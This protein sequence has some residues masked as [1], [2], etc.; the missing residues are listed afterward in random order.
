M[1]AAL[2][3]GAA[4]A[5]AG[6]AGA[7]C[8]R[9]ASAAPAQP[10][11]L[12]FWAD[13]RQQ[14]SGLV[15]GADGAAAGARGQ[16][17]RRHHG[18]KVSAGPSSAGS[19]A[20]WRRT[21]MSARQTTRRPTAIKAWLRGRP[22]VQAILPGGR[23]E[24]QIAGAPVELLGL[25]DHAT[26]REHWPLLESSRNAWVRLRPGDAALVSEQLARRL[27]LGTRRSHRSAGA[28]RQL[29]AR[30]R[31]HL[32]RLRQPE[33]PDRRQ[34]RRADPALSRHPAD[35]LWPARRAGGYSG[36]DG[37]AAATSSAST[38][39]ASPTRRR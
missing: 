36:A 23:A 24:T 19:T 12:W 9:S 32:C 34:Y 33:G 38:T 25:P 28:R 26:Y 16:C 14:L 13:S 6:D 18:A 11:A 10:L 21:S 15:A 5:P 3:L 27:K 8:C 20:G 37:G 17:R 22:E 2:L 1:L 29:A 30:D 39:A 31:R 35:P 4:L 7:A